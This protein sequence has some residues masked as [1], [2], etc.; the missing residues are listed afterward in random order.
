MVPI[1]HGWQS[2]AD[3]TSDRARATLGRQIRR[4]VSWNAAN[5]LVNKGMSILVR[6]LL[7]RLLLPEHFGLIAMIVVILGLVKNFVD[8]GLKNALI[9]RKRDASSLIRYDSAFWFL[10]GGGIGWTLLF[11]VACIPLMIWFYDEP[12]LRELAL[13]MS[14][15]ILL[16]S[17]S[18]LP[19]VRLTRRMRFKSQVI[20]EFISTVVASGIAIAMAFAG[21]GVWALAAQQLCAVGLRSAMLW[22]AVR[23]R[24]RR[25]FSWKSLRDVVGFSRWMLGTRLTDFTRANFDRVAIGALL[26][27]SSLGIYAVAFTLT[28]QLRSQLS[29]VLTRVLLPAFSRVQDNQELLRA[30]FF[31][32]TERIC[33]FIFPIAI[34]IYLHSESLVGVAFSSDWQDA[35]ELA[36]ILSVSIMIYAL[37]GPSPELLI[38]VKKPNLVFIIS[39]INTIFV[40]VPTTLVLVYI[41]GLSGAAYSVVI[42]M[43]GIRARYLYFVNR[44]IIIS[45]KKFIA[46][47][48]PGVIFGL[49]IFLIG[50]FLPVQLAVWGALFFHVLGLAVLVFIQPG[51]TSK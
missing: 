28:E 51:R 50:N 44:I 20:A 25:R 11:I 33:I 9:Q 8:F 17:F 23:L 27:A 34:Q 2:M 14:L 43:V 35:A 48:A 37:S 10:L 7:A 12:Q 29:Q 15:S 18:I 40:V 45:A 1:W 13:V 42:S 24:P 5:L 49:L 30:E 19:E 38:A 4:G 39:L 21:A 32:A 16:H 31:A 46:S 3:T 22:R 41:F 6:L 26:G 36:Q 47:L